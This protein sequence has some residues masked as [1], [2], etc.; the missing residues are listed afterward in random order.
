MK[1][2]LTALTALTLLTT[3]ACQGSESF[4]ISANI[5]VLTCVGG[6]PKCDQN[7]TTGTI[8]AI[9]AGGGIFNPDI[10]TTNFVDL[11]PVSAEKVEKI[12]VPSTPGAQSFYKFTTA[13]GRTVHLGFQAQPAPRPGT[14][15]YN[16]GLKETGTKDF[17]FV[18]LFR[19]SHEANDWKRQN[20]LFVPKAQESE[21]INIKLEPNGNA[22]AVA[23]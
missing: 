10:K 14:H 21:P 5:G 19:F 18:E 16:E 23:S 8:N 9:A 4:K 1:K 15:Y 12:V 3:L 22:V 11:G 17:N 2:Q 13:D 6:N 20:L 7:Q